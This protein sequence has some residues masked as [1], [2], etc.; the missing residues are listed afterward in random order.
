[1]SKR[2]GI[3]L[4]Y[5]F[6]EKRLNKWNPPYIVQPKLDGERCR[7]IWSETHGYVLVSSEF[8]TIISVPHIN[9]AL[10]R[11]YSIAELDGELYTHGLSFSEIHSRVSRTANLHPNYEEI[12]FHIFDII[13]HEPQTLRLLELHNRVAAFGPVKIVPQVL[14]NTFDEVIDAYN[15]FLKDG[16]EGMIVRHPGANYVRRRSPYMMKFKPKKDDYYLIKGYSMELDKNGNPKLGML[17]RIICSSDENKYLPFLFDYPPH[18][19]LPEG[20]FGIGSGLTREQREV[21]WSKRV[22]LI[23]KTCHVAYQNITPG[24]G[25]PRFPVFLSVE[26]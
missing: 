2:E 16:Y 20:Y 23:G 11:C 9:K 26:E 18:K 21:Y 7:A 12:E 14:A 1:M 24:K 3:Q 17:G 13:N 4:C 8:N 25:V 5:P 6:E 10:E 19:K 22:Q 15:G